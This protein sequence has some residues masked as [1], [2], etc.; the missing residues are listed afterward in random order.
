VFIV[1][2]RPLHTLVI[3][4]VLA[5]VQ[6]D[7]KRM[8]AFS[9]ITRA[10]LM[11]SASLRLSATS[12]DEIRGVAKRQ[13]ALGLGLTVLLLAHAGVPLTNDFVTKFGV[14]QAAVNVG[15]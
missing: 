4:A 9:S 7:V 2:V 5:V 11:Q 8:L 10:G 13:P 15:I 14:I 1:M 12:F 3:G 6:T